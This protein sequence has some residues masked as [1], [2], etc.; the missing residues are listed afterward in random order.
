[1]EFYVCRS[2]HSV[3]WL[4]IPFHALC[5]VCKY[6]IFWFQVCLVCQIP[7]VISQQWHYN[8]GD[9]YHHRNVLTE[10]GFVFWKLS[11]E[12]IRKKTVNPLGA[13]QHNSEFVSLSS[14][15]FNKIIT[16]YSCL[17]RD[18]LYVTHIRKYNCDHV[19]CREFVCLGY[20]VVTV[21]LSYVACFSH[22][23]L[24]RLQAL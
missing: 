3:D 9:L 21:S 6:F 17:Y 12:W 13:V 7:H 8:R 11:V 19:S 15:F 24:C 20:H 18:I 5:V 23:F 14:T 2:C 4:T 16:K 1:M 10:K 22:S